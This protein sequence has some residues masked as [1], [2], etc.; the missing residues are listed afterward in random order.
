MTDATVHQPSAPA[1]KHAHSLLAAD[2]RTRKRNAAERRFRMY[3]IAAI[4][5]GLIF[6][7]IL[8]FTIIRNGIPAFTQTYITVEVELPEAKLD[9]PQSVEAQDIRSR[10]VNQCLNSRTKER[11]HMWGLGTSH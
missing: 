1:S 11:I 4:S 5:V 9:K 7:V 6:L 10:R 3:G 2:A 8:L